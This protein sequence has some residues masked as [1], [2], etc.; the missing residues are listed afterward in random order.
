ME[1]TAAASVVR[2]TALA[3]RSSG[4]R[5]WSDGNGRL[6]VKEA[7]RAVEALWVADAHGRVINIEG[8]REFDRRVLKSRINNDT[9]WCSE[10]AVPN[11]PTRP[12]RLR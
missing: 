10:N 6:Y 7:G 11:H 4:S 2:A 9:E 1:L 12:V 5:V 8:I 3:H